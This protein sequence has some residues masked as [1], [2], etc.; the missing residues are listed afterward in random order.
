MMGEKVMP[1]T[2]T[3]PQCAQRLNIPD[4][5]RSSRAKCP[6]CGSAI[7]IPPASSATA[8]INGIRVKV[9]SAKVGKVQLQRLSGTSKSSN[10]EYIALNVSVE[11]RTPNR[12]VN[13]QS[14][15]NFADSSYARD[16]AGNILGRVQFGMM[17]PEGQSKDMMRM[18][19]PGNS[20]TDV[21]VFTKPNEGMKHLRLALPA[22][23]VGASGYF[24]FEIPADMVQK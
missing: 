24:R 23:S 17:R 2:V 14:W 8:D 19:Q 12:T 11:N 18:L 16:N 20:T 10:G 3:C 22:Q 7:D 6:K 1:Q 4:S 9:V 5:F 15:G 21:I 13:Y